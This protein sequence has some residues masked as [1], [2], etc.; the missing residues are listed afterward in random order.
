MF[1]LRQIQHYRDEC[2]VVARS[3]FTAAEL[4]ELERELDGIYARRMAA[5]NPARRDVG[6]RFEE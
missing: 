2:Y 4:D 3:I 1:S 5:K 6:R